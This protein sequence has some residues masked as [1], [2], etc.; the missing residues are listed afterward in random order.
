M[1]L[2]SVL[3]VTRLYS[4]NCEGTY[5]RFHDIVHTLLQMHSPPIRPRILVVNRYVGE[6]SPSVIF[7]GGNRLQ[8]IV[9][10][11]R[12]LRKESRETDIVHIVQAAPLISLLPMLATP[13]E[14]PVVLGPNISLG[15]GR[16]EKQVIYPL[17]SRSGILFRARLSRHFQ[18][19]LI[20]HRRSPLNRRFYRRMVFSEIHKA[21]NV[22]AGMASDEIDV[23]PSGVRTDIF[24]PDGAQIK[25][26]DKFTILCQCR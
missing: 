18:T 24:T 8:R 26:P 23:L 6:A 12:A 13:R 21:W 2:I 7:G 1:E 19:R 16:L 9:N 3:Y 15:Q 5:G 11:N 17:F 4:Q 14:T 20:V 25:R 10:F 22:S